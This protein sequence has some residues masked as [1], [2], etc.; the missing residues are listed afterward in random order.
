[1]VTVLPAF[2]PLVSEW[3][4]TPLRRTHRTAGARLARNPRRARRSHLRAHRFRQDAGRLPA[5]PSTTWCAARASG[6]CPSKPKSSTSRRSRRSAT[7]STRTSKSRWP[8]SPRWPRS[9]ASRW[10]PS[11]PPL[12]TGDTPQC[13]APADDASTARTSW[14][15]RPNRCTS[16]SPPTSRARCCARVRT[17]IVDEIHAVADD[18]RGSHLALTLARLDR[19]VEQSGGRK[20]QRIGLSATV[21]PIEEVAAF[22][23]RRRA[24]R[25]RRPPPRDGAGGR[26][27]ARRARPGRQQRDVGRDLRP[28]RRTDP[29]APHH[30]GLRQHAPPVRARGA[31][32]GRAPRAENAVLPH[33]GSLSRAL[34]L[35][36]E[37]PAQERRAAR[38]RG[39][40]VAR[41]RHRHRHRRPGLPDRLAA[42]HRGGA[43]AHRPLRP[44]G[45]RAAQRPPLRHH[46]RRADRMRGPGARHPRRRARPA[47]D[48]RERRSTFWRSRSWPP[49][50]ARTGPKT[51][52]SPWCAAPGPTARSTARDFD[53]VI[54]DA[55][56]KASPP[57]AAAAAPT[58]IATR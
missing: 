35:E 11:A 56:A 29:R 46:A 41:T 47:R 49:A 58:C 44:L 27:A 33:H 25:Q 4:A 32:P 39:D 55:L 13:G 48:S 3:F 30:A 51:S 42:L 37:A 45:G 5:L 22:P 1:M 15:P 18:K 21:K 38:R 57:R 36:A 9:A 50:P 14:S 16:C 43:A 2:D 34:R 52:C 17:V 10:R 28:R 24:R 20:P 53:D 26:S 8:K 31:P 40:R 7:T 12:R 54:D 23:Q 19:L 6:R